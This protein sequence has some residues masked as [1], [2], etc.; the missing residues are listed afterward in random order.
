M[1]CKECKKEIKMKSFVCYNQSQTCSAEC[2]QIEINNNKL[3]DERV[4]LEREL[5]VEK[6]MTFFENSAKSHNKLTFDCPECESKEKASL[7]S[8]PTWSNIGIFVYILPTNFLLS[9][10]YKCAKCGYLWLVPRS[11]FTLFVV[12][13]ISLLA[14]IPVYFQ[15]TVILWQDHI[16]KLH[17]SQMTKEEIQIK[18]AD[19]GSGNEEAI[20]NFIYY[21]AIALFVIWPS[22]L[23]L[24]IVINA[25][26]IFK[27]G[28]R[29]K[30]NA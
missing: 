23:V 8:L 9:K 20:S 3:L 13:C 21:I 28:R 7:P 19:G 15:S 4:E 18:L 29:M 6:G 17:P 16:D 24:S 1:E 22:I 25:Y 12:V 2:R 30:L 27:I 5:Q 14:L 10:K 26:R 11:F